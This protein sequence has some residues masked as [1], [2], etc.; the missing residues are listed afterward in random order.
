MKPPV[1]VLVLVVF[2]LGLLLPV[3][4]RA[5]SDTRTFPETG[6]SVS[7]RFLEFWRDNGGLPIFGYPLSPELEED[8]VRVQFFER[9]VFEYR[10]SNLR[11]YDVLLRLVG[12]QLRGGNIAPPAQRAPN[13]LWFPDTGHNVCDQQQGLGFASYWQQH[14]LEFDG[15]TRSKSYQES[16]ALFGLPITEAFEETAPDGTRLLVQWFERARFE[17]HPTNPAATRVVLGRLGAEVRAAQPQPGPS[18][19][20]GD[21]FTRTVQVFLISTDDTVSSTPIGCGDSVVPVTFRIDPTPE[22]LG[23]ALNR[24]LSLKQP[25]YAD[26]GLYN[27]LANSNLQVETVAI[28]NGAATIG[29]TGQLVTGGVCDAPRVQTQLER[30]V[31]QFPFIRSVRFI[32]NGQPL[33]DALS[34]R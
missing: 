34:E 20:S 28:D 17:W 27:A 15:R 29:L 3:H 30:T 25:F 10:P 32:I 2:A 23:P 14:G 19:D 16:L 33:A 26:T 5:Q 21:Q 1:R 6:F 18:S 11:P 4:S 7:G 13:C 9:A 12:L 31:L 24:L 8:G 22:P